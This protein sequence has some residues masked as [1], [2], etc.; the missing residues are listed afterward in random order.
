MDAVVQR[1]A[2]DDR[3]EA[4]A[5]ERRRE[6]EQL[7]MGTQLRMHAETLRLQG[8]LERAEERR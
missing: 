6:A 7:D 5:R 4:E 2:Q 1:L 8:D 3:L